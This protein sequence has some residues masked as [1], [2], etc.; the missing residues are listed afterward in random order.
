MLETIKKLQVRNEVKLDGSQS[1][2]DNDGKIVSF[3]WEQTDG[4]KVNLNSDQ[5]KATFVVKL[6]H[7][8]GNKQMV[9]KL[10]STLIKT[11]QR[12]LQTP[13]LIQIL[14]SN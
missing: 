13:L 5:D 1:L 14:H 6:F 8:N 9:Q 2:H 10:I 11:K 12:L 7:S 3:K 4:P